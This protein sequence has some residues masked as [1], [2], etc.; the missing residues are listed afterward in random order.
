MVSDKSRL[1]TVCLLTA[2]LWGFQIIWLDRDTRPPVWDMALH[3]TYALNYTESTRPASADHFRPWE[4]SGHY[5]P[6]VHWM[7][8]AAFLIFHPGPHIA[9]LA[10]IPATLILLW[11]VYELAKDLAGPIAACWACLLT[12]LTPYLIWISRETVLDYWLAAWFVAALVAL[13]KTHG[14][15]SRSWSVFLGIIMAFG[16]LSKWFFL[17]FILTPL[18][19]VFYK[20]RVWQN[21]TRLI[22]LADALII[23]GV[24][25][26]LW[27][28]P[29]LP[30][31]VRHFGE[32]AKIGALEGEPPVFSFQ[33]FIYY[34]RLLEGYQ[35][36]GILFAVLCF[37][38][39]FVWRKKL[40]KDWGFLALAIAG[41]WLIMTLLRTKDPRFTLP[42]IG[43]FSIISGAWIAS[44]K[45]TLWNRLAQVVLVALLCFQVY[46]SNFGISWLPERAI[47]LRGYQGS[48]RWD[49]NL[50]LQDYFDIFG[51]PKAEDW[52]Q[53]A[54]I[55]RIA[56]DS[57]GKNIE[58][59]LALVPDLPFFN[60]S[61]FAY[62][63]RLRG[64]PVRVSHLKSAANGIQSYDGYNYVLMTEHDQGMPWTTGASSE[65]NQMI[66]DNPDI[67]RLV[68]LYQLPTGDGARLYYIFREQPSKQL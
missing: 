28:L 60:E 23:S 38:C 29:N 14:F 55:R 24:A 63:A 48:L 12:V 9:V 30:L 27:Y 44:W 15:Q 51:M 13:R 1:I 65:L 22:H 54:V 8:A 16:L 11:A 6:F 64:V 31:L 36:F 40:I 25:S 59:T 46:L 45:A 3:Q 52:K 34:L 47:I 4:R 39:I 26:G 37:A 35:L 7:I 68:E 57:K 33:S 61:N 67:F 10:N 62:Y 58:P 43:L 49:W 66:V 53:D 19:Y 21:Q 56:E 42:L 5:P 32:N 41:G 50:Y 20:S 17:G 2:L 18:A